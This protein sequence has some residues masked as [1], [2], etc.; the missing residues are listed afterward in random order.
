MMHRFLFFDSSF[1]TSFDN[2]G[3]SFHNS[4]DNCFHMID[5]FGTRIHDLHIVTTA[6][7]LHIDVTSDMS[8]DTYSHMPFGNSPGTG[9]LLLSPI[10]LFRRYI[11]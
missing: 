3:N 5:N 1:R 10:K 7:N 9:L 6:D 8:P 4:S 11:S 2:L